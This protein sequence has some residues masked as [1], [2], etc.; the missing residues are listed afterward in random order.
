MASS[1]KRT[2][3]TARSAICP[4]NR[5]TAQGCD[6]GPGGRGYLADRSRDIA[7]HRAGPGRNGGPPDP[8]PGAGK[9]LDPVPAGP[10]RGSHHRRT[11]TA[12]R[13]IGPAPSLAVTRHSP[14][15]TNGN[16]PGTRPRGYRK[17]PCDWP[18]PGHGKHWSVVRSAAGCSTKHAT[19]KRP[20]NSNGPATSTAAQ[21]NENTSSRPANKPWT[22]HLYSAADRHHKG[23]RCV[24]TAHAGSRK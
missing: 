16:T 8:V 15:H 14:R 21:G 12:G 13:F 24:R 10:D 2:A 11:E 20:R 22:E 17:K 6:P 7:G 9:G 3:G 19:A 4:L 5:G 18:I 23:R 1:G